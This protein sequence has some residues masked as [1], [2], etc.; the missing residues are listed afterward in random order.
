MGYDSKMR[1]AT[2]SLMNY[3]MSVC[4][5]VELLS[6]AGHRRVDVDYV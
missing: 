4:E 2:M 5:N 3:E 1:G 6:N